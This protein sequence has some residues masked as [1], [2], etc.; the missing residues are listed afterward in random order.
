[1]DLKVGLDLRVCFF[2]KSFFWEV[3]GSFDAFEEFRAAAALA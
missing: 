1:M 2:A 3:S